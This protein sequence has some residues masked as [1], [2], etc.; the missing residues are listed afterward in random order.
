MTTGI[1]GTSWSGLLV[2]EYS[3]SRIVGGPLM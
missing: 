2:C 1:T 3:E